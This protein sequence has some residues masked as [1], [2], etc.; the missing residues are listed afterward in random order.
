MNTFYAGAL[1]R[2]R[3]TEGV[4]YCTDHTLLQIVLRYTVYRLY[5]A[6]NN[7]L[8]LD[9]STDKIRLNSVTGRAYH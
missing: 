2:E 1:L 7:E 6:K 8:V 3:R 9:H 4:A 5:T